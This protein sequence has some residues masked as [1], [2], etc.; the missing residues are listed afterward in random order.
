MP[1]PIQTG[2]DILVL[3]EAPL[4]RMQYCIFYI[5]AADQVVKCWD[6]VFR[7]SKS[8]EEKLNLLY[9]MNDVVQTSRKKGTQ[10]SNAFQK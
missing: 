10:F 9:L 7:T 4:Y 8:Y 2:R 6:E 1:S 5:S 3:I